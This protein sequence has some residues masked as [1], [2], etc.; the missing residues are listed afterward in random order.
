[1]KKNSILIVT[2]ILTIIFVFTSCSTDPYTTGNN[3]TKVDSFDSDTMEKVTS[4]FLKNV[5]NKYTNLYML[6]SAEIAYASKTDDDITN[7][8]NA[9]DFYLE[10]ATADRIP[11]TVMVFGQSFSYG[12]KL[13]ASIGNNAYYVDYAWKY[14]SNTGSVYVNAIALY[15]SIVYQ[16]IPMIDNQEILIAEDSGITVNDITQTAL[17]T[18][19]FK[20]STTN[21]VSIDTENAIISVT[22]EDGSNLLTYSYE[23]ISNSTVEAGSDIILIRTTYPALGKMVI[24]LDHSYDR[25]FYLNGY[26]TTN[27]ETNTANG[28]K[29]A[30]TENFQVIK[31]LLIYSSDMEYKGS[32]KFT[33]NVDVILK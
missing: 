26:Y 19:Q 27:E 5:F 12:D 7:D 28:F 24:S 21:T 6:E 25:G 32:I 2:A 17:N 29:P 15:Y 33:F 14:D 1:M 20:S 18:L 11:E 10:I 13:Q 8:V 22:I 16:E 3:I 23:G 4:Y 30:F 9:S 31:E